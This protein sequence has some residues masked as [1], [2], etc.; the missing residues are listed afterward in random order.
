MNIPQSNPYTLWVKNNQYLFILLMVLIEVCINLTRLLAPVY[1]VEKVVAIV[2]EKNQNF[3]KCEKD[4]GFGVALYYIEIVW[5]CIVEA[6]ILFLIFIEWN[7]KSTTNEIRFITA[8]VF[9]TILAFIMYVV[10]TRINL[11]NYIAYNLFYAGIIYVLSVSNHFFIYGIR[12]IQALIRN[13]ELEER[14]AFK[15]N[16]SIS[17]S[18]NMS[19]ISSESAEYSKTGKISTVNYTTQAQVQAT[20]RSVSENSKS[21]VS[22]NNILKLHYTESYAPNE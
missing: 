18:K 15:N 14:E 7:L 1:K 11:E 16:K 8:S 21:K 4:K 5:M 20:N 17:N 10:I 6:C 13:E 3:E 2:N 12:I 22:N 9:V 19:S